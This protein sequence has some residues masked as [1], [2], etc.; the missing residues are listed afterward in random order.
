MMRAIPARIFLAALAATLSAGLSGCDFRQEAIALS[1]WSL[2]FSRNEVPF[3]MYV[4][5]LNITIP[6]L[7]VG[8]E[9][10]QDWIITNVR[11]VTSS[12]P[13]DA[14]KGPFDKR[15]VFVRIDRTQLAKGVHTGK[16]FFTSQGIKPKEATVRV[17]MDADGRLASLNITNPT[18]TY[19]SPYLVDFLFGL[20]DSRGNAVVAEPA[21]FG[22]EA[23]ED[24]AQVGGSNGLQL[25]RAASLQL[26]MDL[27]MDYSLAMQEGFA[28]VP[29]ME[30]TAVNVLLP[31]LNTGALVGVT[32]F[33][34]DDRDAQ[35]VTDFTLDRAHLR[36]RIGAIQ[37]EYVRGF[38]SGARLYDAVYFSTRKFTGGDPLQESRYIVLFTDG[39][40]TSS[41]RGLDDAVNAA[42]ERNIRIYAIGCGP[43]AN[44]PV[45]L[46]LTGRTGGAYFP[47]DTV[48]RLPEAIGDILDNLEGQ[49]ILR[50]ASLRRRNESVRP[51]FSIIL[52]D[53]RASYTAKEDFNPRN[54]E[55]N[56]LRG[57]LRLV[58]SGSPGET[59]VMLRAD[60]IPRFVRQIALYVRSDLNFVVSLAGP[61][62]EGLL[63]GWT[64]ETTRDQGTGGLWIML[65]S[66][67]P[68]VPFASFGPML[69]FDF[70]GYVDPNQPLFE[71]IFADNS[72]Y[73]EGIGL[74]ILGF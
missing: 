11:E 46:D 48:D 20:K 49:Y 58:D 14:E 70:P 69:R 39:Y 62:D 50:W 36:E 73:E 13:K 1:N 5:N 33:H 4:W 72:L 8:V 35:S 21:Q 6:K 25:R 63:G 26:K 47:A 16:L 53:G 52:G 31:A 41:V 54:H 17:V 9:S 67:G 12:A 55:G 59:T 2:D 30:D 37:S 65:D 61:A 51:S 66:P 38:Y 71:E 10:D 56:V 28:A 29:V 64:M 45:L 44:L 43:G 57:V 3:T 19:S 60:Y 74:D 23:Y 18:A 27:V 42:K 22:V 68:V 24:D 32:E 34:R 7:T 40:D 15:V